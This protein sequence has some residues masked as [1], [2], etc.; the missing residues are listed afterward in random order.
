MKIRHKLIAV[1]ML[2]CII[3]LV[4]VSSIFIIWQRE[5]ARKSM[6][7][8][9][10]TQAE[11]IADNCKAAI[12]FDD[13]QDAKETLNTLRLET[14]IVHAAVYKNNGDKFV[15]YYREDTEPVIHQ[16][17]VT[18]DGYRFDNGML[19]VFKN[20]VVDG[21]HV[22]TVSLDST[23]DPLRTALIQ[24]LSMVISVLLCSS[25]AAYLLSTRLQ[26]IISRPILDLTNAA[27]DVSEKKE[28]SIRVI[29]KSND[30]IGVLIASFNEMLAQ[31]QAH[32]TQLLEIN[33]SLEEK[34]NDRTKELTKAKELAEEANVA[35]SQFLA[36]MSHEI[37]TPMNAIIGFSDLLSEEDLTK[38]QREDVEI[39][40]ESAKNL[41][42][43]IN[44]I[45]DFS[46]IEAGQ[47]QTEIIDCSLSKTINSVESMMR[48]KATEKGIEFEII[49][50]GGLPDIIKSD[51]T[52]LR[53]CLIN[54][55]N[56]AIKFTDKGHV[57]VSVS[58]ENDNSKPW[59]RF[60]VEDTG[61]GIPEEKQ[62]LVFE[63]FTQADGSHTRKYGGTGLGLAITRQLSELLGGTITL[64]SEGGKGSVFTLK[65]PPGVEIGNGSSLYTHHIPNGTILEKNELESLEFFGHVLVAEDTPTNQM[66]IEILLKRMGLQI[67]IVEDGNH[68][69]QAALTKEFDLILMDIQMPHMNGYAATS[70]LRKNGITTPIVALT[71]NAM[72]G[73][74]VKC[75][76]AGC[77]GYLSKPIDR[78]KLIEIIRTYLP[79]KTVL[80]DTES[81]HR[82]VDK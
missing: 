42:L 13:P 80:A 30:E 16:D 72:K 61:I 4:M 76:E 81:H 82:E 47:L 6:V 34:V 67:T 24:N 2:T 45:L 20:I 10:S 55:I 17:E 65:I 64:K 18:R 11:M 54:L 12:V 9:L 36:T 59:I 44:D 70:E 57:H 77:D 63:A 7:R 32:K 25:L 3:S 41:L 22:G 29:E 73:D 69:I 71:A 52:R 14:S 51:P 56:N 35:K 74:D 68:A 40:R 60:D 38:D 78:N 53:Q 43:L 66:L 27:K 15:E 19:S 39:I 75:F 1:I 5:S 46:K 79:G 37:R 50:T 31:I 62:E 48:P 33:E 21:S 28:Y 58:I 49:E 23:L 26:G 8:N